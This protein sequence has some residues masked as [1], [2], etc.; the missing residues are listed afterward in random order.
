MQGKFEER[1]FQGVPVSEGI[2]IGAPFFLTEEQTQVPEFPISLGEVDEEI[3]RYRRALSFS[4]EDLRQL[5]SDLSGKGSEDAVTIL[6]THIQML[7]DP[8]MT[9]QMEEKIRRMLRNTESVFNLAI[10]DYGDRI[11]QL[12][13]KFFQQR[14]VDVMD[15]AQR[16]LGHLSDR[17][18]HS[19]KEI[20]L[21]SVVFTR[22]LT[23]SHSAAAR[24]QHVCAFVSKLGSGH[25]HAALIARAKGIPYVSDIDIEILLTV[26]C[27]QVIV[28]GLTGEVILNPS[29]DTLEKYRQ[30]K[31]ALRVSAQALQEESHYDT[32]TS[33]GCPVRVYANLGDLGGID[34][35]ASCGADGVGLFRTEYLVL[36]DRD[37]IFSEEVQ[38]RV[39]REIIQK[40]KGAPAV[41]RVFDVGGEKTPDQMKKEVGEEEGILGCR[42]IRYLLKRP[43]L[44]KI[45]L[46]ALLRAG[47][48]GDLRLLLPLIS[49]VRELLEAYRMI[50]EIMEELESE[51]VPYKKKVPVGCMI[52]VPSAVLICDL[53]AERCDFVAIGTNDLMQ[54]TLGID[55]SHAF[56]KEFCYPVHPSVIRMIKMVVTECRR[57]NRQ[58][59][60]CGEIASNPLFTPL[61][62]GLGVTELSCAPRYVS[63]IKQAVRKNSLLNTFDLAERI[64]RMSSSAEIFQVLTQWSESIL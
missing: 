5:Q 9:T 29:M 8:M 44:F 52:E 7:E 3:E 19:V 47:L 43:D 63:R 31:N 14:M 48:E 21:D 1:R 58:V 55:R 54:Y 22:E 6:D 51:G 20:P 60:I 36:E 18:R 26:A 57:L 49:D 37:F 53:L 45:Q 27:R 38:H 11:S 39:Y 25:S 50:E 42:G 33:D 30:K 64:L 2:A 32:E 40:M 13:N 62:L 4:R 46:R 15:L 10:R 23:P 59:S 16:V 24:A 17:A 34:E 28:D 56:T 61:L 41:I 12:P 35:V